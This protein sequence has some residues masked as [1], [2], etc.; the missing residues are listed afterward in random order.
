MA[1]VAVVLLFA[2]GLPL[3]DTFLT[4]TRRVVA[5]GTQ[6][7]LITSDE[8]PA[9]SDPPGDPTVRFV[10]AAG[11]EQT[12]EGEERYDRV[13]LTNNGVS[14]ELRVT[15]APDGTDCGPALDR[16]ESRLQ[17]D[18]G[19]GR[20]HRPQTFTTDS[21][22][23]GV[24]APFIGARVEALVF[25]VCSRGVSATMVASGPVGA[26]Q[27]V[28]ADADPVVGMARSVEIG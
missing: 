14:F 9:I 22:Q 11:W 19:S 27:G 8:R 12:D 20:L 24:T 7:D 4:P 23:V 17:E 6:V 13:A 15:P 3:L 21:G 16:A 2:A 10:P 28:A 26:L 1:V 18:D 5:A 25:A